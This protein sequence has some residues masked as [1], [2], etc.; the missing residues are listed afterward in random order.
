M[1]LA[2]GR[3]WDISCSPV[4]GCC[5]P[6]GGCRY[7]WAASMA[8]RFRS[9]RPEWDGV[10]NELGRWNRRVNFNYK[11]LSTFLQREGKI[12][13]C[14]WMG[15]LFQPAVPEMYI[16]LVLSF[17]ASSAS[18]SHRVLMLTKFAARMREIWAD[19]KWTA[20]LFPTAL[21]H[22]KTHLLTQL[23]LPSTADVEKQYPPRNIWWGVSITTQKEA[24][25]KLPHLMKMPA[26]R[27]VSLEPLLEVVDLE[28]WRE[29]I[30]WVAIGGE[31]GANARPL[32]LGDGIRQVEHCRKL[33]IPVFFKQ[34]GSFGRGR[35]KPR[36]DP[37][38][39]LKLI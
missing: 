32:H 29:H 38:P 36:S 27:W 33:G 26:P 7:C 12:L 30:D 21:A 18:H 4:V 17:A 34:W 16:R 1:N 22:D 37:L 24:Q 5:H 13:A 31:Q 25:A 9:S 15:D 11:A 23:A 6:S 2:K 10:T 20:G 35:E 19:T 3:Y 14:N 28:C 8:H 39:F